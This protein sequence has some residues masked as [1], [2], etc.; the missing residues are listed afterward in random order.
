MK[1]VFAALACCV[2]FVSSVTAQDVL[3][4]IVADSDVIL[5]SVQEPTPDVQPSAT[6][7]PMP[8]YAQDQPVQGA[9]VVEGQYVQPMPAAGGCG[10]GP[11]ATSYASPV[12]SNCCQPVCC[13]NDRSRTQFLNRFRGRWSLFGGR[14]NQCCCN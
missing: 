3:S 14:N 4:S 13:Q 12:A 2:L 8:Q 7:A 5:T 1:K 10:C 11:V 9:T 6:D